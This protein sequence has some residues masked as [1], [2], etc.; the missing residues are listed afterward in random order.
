MSFK[1]FFIY[2]VIFNLLLALAPLIADYYFS[3]K[4]LLIPKFWSIFWIFSIL[5][6]NIFVIASWRMKIS[7]RA[8]G[9]ALLGIITVKMLF[10]MILAFFY[11]RGNTFEPI[12][13]IIN[14][15][16]LYFFHT[17]FEI[18]CLL[19]NLRNQKFK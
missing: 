9:Q 16:Y 12:N 17:V 8:S 2:F 3:D 14:F 18:Y 10:S 1:R 19:C 15:F 5:T 6:F 4:D 7:D 13:F 11:I